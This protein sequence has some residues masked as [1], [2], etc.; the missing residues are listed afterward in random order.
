[1]VVR[2][3]RVL[4]IVTAI[5]MFLVLIMGATVTNTGSEHGCGKSWPLCH[6]QFI[7]KMAVSTAIEFS[8]RAVVGV[9]S[10]LIIALAV[11]AFALYRTRR[12]IQL[13][14]P[15]MVLFLF[16]QAGLGA[17]AVMQPQNS[18]ALALHF[19]V[20]LVAFA[21]VLLTAIFLFEVDGWD[22]LR[23]R[24]LPAS[25][26]VYVW[27]LTVY[28]YA[29]VY[30]GAYVRHTDSDEACSG[31]PRCNG[32]IIPAFHDKVGANFTHR[33]AA[34]VLTLA[35][36]LLVLWA[37]RYRASRPDIYR[38]SHIA[39]GMVLLQALSGAIVAWTR[40]DLF[41]AL[42]HAGLVGLLFGSLAY[43]CVHVLRS[44]AVPATQPRNLQQQLAPAE[45]VGA[46][47]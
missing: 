43:L 15:L 46:G 21:S 18:A 22:R 13:L 33:V 47:S 45:S 19:G 35:I 3:T 38:A 31:W 34:G 7:P 25:F 40:V 1:M 6:G 27:G 2:F 30:L 36:V 17:W 14:A 39:F 24:P 5:G 23:A 11:I 16:L 28:A 8:H 26:R 10:V 29:V 37:A 32:A 44:S 42:A 9:E 20:S 41:S 12:E 4:A